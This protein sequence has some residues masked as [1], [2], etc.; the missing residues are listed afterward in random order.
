MKPV[1]NSF[2]HF[3]DD[4]LWLKVLNIGIHWKG[5]LK[6]LGAEWPQ[7]SVFIPSI[8]LKEARKNGV[9]N[10]I[11]DRKLFDSKQRKNLLKTHIKIS[12][13]HNDTGDKSILV[14]AI[15]W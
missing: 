14:V 1:V 13:S 4:F 5:L 9:S 8:Q 10:V 6:I 15:I 2:T 3:C 7:V 11:K 12:Y